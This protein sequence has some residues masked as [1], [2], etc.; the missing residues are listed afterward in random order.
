MLTPDTYNPIPDDSS[1]FTLTTHLRILRGSYDLR[2]YNADLVIYDENGSFFWTLSDVM[3]LSPS[4]GFRF[5]VSGQLSCFHSWHLT[6]ETLVPMSNFHAIPRL[7]GYHSHFP[8]LNN[9]VFNGTK[10]AKK[11]EPK[12]GLYFSR[13]RL[14]NIR[15]NR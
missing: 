14:T 1:G 9:E 3:K 15:S 6:P 11:N 13:D 4:M 8:K 12:S 5:R 2:L 7:L 10:G